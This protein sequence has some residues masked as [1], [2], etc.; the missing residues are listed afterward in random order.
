[1][2]APC[3]ELTHRQEF[4]AAHRLHDPA[5]SDEENR[6]LYGPC[7]NPR[8]HGHNYEYEVTVRGPVPRSGM[9]LD[10]NVLT[11]IM[12]EEI[13]AHVDHKHLDHDVPF[14]QGRIST[15][16]NLCIAF[17]ERLAPRLAGYDGCALHRI[18]VY[19][20]RGSFVDYYG[21]DA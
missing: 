7:N 13:F 3:L 21:P 12:R 16:E 10:L 18:R 2:P 8:G 14:L 5:L 17:W 19:E 1:M 11:V 15:A 9:I 20:T 4:S 6:R